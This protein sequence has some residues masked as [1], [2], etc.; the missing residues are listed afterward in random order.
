MFSSLEMRAGR[1]LIGCW[2][3]AVVW[4][5]V[6]TQ[7]AVAQLR[8][9]RATRSLT[10]TNNSGAAPGLDSSVKSTGNRQASQARAQIRR[11]SGGA[12]YASF[13]SP[14]TEPALDSSQQ[15]GAVSPSMPSPI[16]GDGSYPIDGGM[17]AS[18][19][20]SGYGDGY[21]GNLFVEHGQCTTGCDDYPMQRVGHGQLCGNACDNVCGGE[22]CG[23]FGTSP[24]QAIVRNLMCNSY[25]RIEGANTG[26]DGAVTPALITTGPATSPLAGRIDQ[27]ETDI[28]FGGLLNDVDN[29]GIRVTAGTWFDAR[30]TRGFLF[31]GFNSGRLESAFSGNEFS[32]GVLTRPFFDVQANDEATNVITFDGIASGSIDA[33]YETEAY[34]AD[35]LYR[36]CISHWRGSRWD[37]LA[38]FQTLRLDDDLTLQSSTFSGGTGTIAIRD[39]FATENRFNGATLGLMHT[40]QGRSFSLE[41]LFKLGFGGVERMVMIDGERTTTISPT[42]SFSESQGLLARNPNNGVFTDDT[43][44]VVPEFGLTLSYRLTSQLDCTLGFS[45]ITIDNVARAGEQIDRNVNLSSPLT[46]QIAPIFDLFESTVSISSLNFGLQYRY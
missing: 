16:V 8:T 26:I 44:V 27:D 29:L 32:H 34:G 17:S 28:L 23:G 5:A 30:R 42:N 20:L 40:M 39:A 13:Q 36:K 12:S 46:G 24:L 15:P 45:H 3:V 31:R 10:L 21:S 22:V 25:F 41:S 6:P 11:G 38:G 35:F 1:A 43:S 2:I 14:A 18:P 9:G 37:L 7:D 4:F 33:T 19:P